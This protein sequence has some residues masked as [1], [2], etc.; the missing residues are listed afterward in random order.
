MMKPICSYS[1]I[2]IRYVQFSCGKKER[3]DLFNFFFLIFKKC[4]EL[5]P[6]PNILSPFHYCYPTTNTQYPVL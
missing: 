6:T 1:A 5:L 2:C 3:K 4:C